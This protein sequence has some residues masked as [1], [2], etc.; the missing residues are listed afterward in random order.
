VPEG[1]ILLSYKKANIAKAKTLR[2]NMTPWERKL[3]YE[4]LH[5]YRV[6]FQRQKAIDNYIVD[7]YCAKAR[8]VI[9][10]DGGGHY[11]EDMQK[12]DAER[13]AVLSQY[14][15][16]LLRFSNLDID[17]NFHEV[18]ASIDNAV[19]KSLSQLGH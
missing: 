16:T 15:L 1:E 10:L 4:F 12:Y 14:H 18:C 17:K 13:T 2:K 5:D 6:R 9:E 11:D 7:F 3:W 19:L 8:L